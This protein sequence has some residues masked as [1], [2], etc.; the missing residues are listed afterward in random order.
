M[1]RPGKDTLFQ[2]NMEPNKLSLN[3]STFKDCKLVELC[4]TYYGGLMRP[5]KV[6]NVTQQ[7]HIGGHGSFPK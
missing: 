1:R 2:R 6:E 3:N 5:A 4:W 7:V